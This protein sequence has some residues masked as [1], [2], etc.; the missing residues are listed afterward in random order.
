MSD[1]SGPDRGWEGP[2]P[3]TERLAALAGWLGVGLPPFEGP[4]AAFQLEGRR[5]AEDPVFLGGD[6]H[7]V[8]PSAEGAGG[9]GDR[10]ASLDGA[11]VTLVDHEREMLDLAAVEG[12]WCTRI[13]GERL[14]AAPFFS[15]TDAEGR[16]RAWLLLP[17]PRLMVDIAHL[18][19]PSVPPPDDP[20]GGKGRG[21]RPP[22]AH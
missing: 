5:G 8:H 20:G 14:L 1:L 12:L 7:A 6:L 13:E 16:T 17:P 18:W 15:L 22:G 11:I 2:D 4:L 9:R 3:R 21:A 10:D 19:L